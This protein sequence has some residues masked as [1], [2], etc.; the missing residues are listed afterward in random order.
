MTS[1]SATQLEEVKIAVPQRYKGSVVGRQYQWFWYI[2]AGVLGG[3]NAIYYFLCMV[4]HWKMRL[5]FLQDITLAV[6]GLIAYAWEARKPW[7]YKLNEHRLELFS[8][9][10]KFQI[11]NLRE[12]EWAK[13][14]S[15]AL[16]R[17]SGRAY[18]A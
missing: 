6:M 14:K 9:S 7:Y 1:G 10:P 18:R 5:L 8:I 4:F 15:S 17:M 3:V 12:L 16:S 11:A 2:L 13:T